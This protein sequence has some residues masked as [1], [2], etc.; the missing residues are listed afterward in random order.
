[1]IIF[2]IESSD[3][4]NKKAFTLIELLAV[5]VILAIIA[6]IAV[7]IVIHIIDDS[8]KSSEEQTVELYM[9]SVKKAIARKQLE[10]TSFN[11]TTCN[12]QDSGNLLCGNIEI[13][14]DMK[15]I[16]PSKGIIEIKDNKITY[17]NLLLNGT[18][19]NRLAI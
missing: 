14:I 16:K 5:I 18:Y 8:K 11:P 19:F 7:P 15:G 3:N 1:M 4:M 6:L 10:D 9:D 12:I 17:K 2:L 13:T